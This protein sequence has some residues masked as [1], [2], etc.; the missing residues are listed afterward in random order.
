MKGFLMDLFVKIF[1][2]F[3]QSGWK[4]V[5]IF[6]IAYL[7]H[8]FGYFFIE[9]AIRK[10]I[11]PDH[12]VSQEAERKREDTLI[13]IINKTLRVLLWLIA[14]LMI[15]SELGLNI[16]P[17]LAGA[18]IAGVALGFG[19]QTLIKDIINGLFIILE[20][21]F[22]VG[23]VIC[24]GKICGKVEDITLRTTVLRDLDGTV[25]YIP[26]GQIKTTSNLSKEF[27]QVHLNIG[28]SYNS[29]L[30]KVEAVINQIG[31][32]IAKDAQWQDDIL[33][34]PKFIRVE[35]FAESAIIVKIIGKTKPLKQW[36]VAGELRKRLKIAFDR[37]GIEIPYQQLEVHLQNNK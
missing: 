32:E 3:W 17:L 18:G 7:I 25:H 11:K 29:D 13:N 24:V 30:E 31:Q 37:Q 33:E 20:N 22:R 4:I 12:F 9:K 5:L 26:N 2:W 15:L 36:A 34:P 10:A 8:R 6:L 14:L 21:Q 28:I 19:A 27:S 35:N 1:P 16:G 23:D